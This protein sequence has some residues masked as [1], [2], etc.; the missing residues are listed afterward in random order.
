MIDSPRP[1]AAPQSTPAFAA[2]GPL[3]GAI[4]LITLALSL[5][6]DLGTPAFL[7]LIG[8]ELL[9]IAGMGALFGT[10]QKQSTT[11]TPAG[12]AERLRDEAALDALEPLRGSE[13]R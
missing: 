7:A 4:A 5:A 1:A 9:L 11:A 2:L 13:Q 10:L 6:D 8:A 12:T 3:L